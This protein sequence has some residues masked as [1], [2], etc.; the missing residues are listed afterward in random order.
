MYWK[1]VDSKTP[2]DPFDFYYMD[3]NVLFIYLF[4]F[5]TEVIVKLSLNL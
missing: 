4:I 1:S 3:K 5:Y 2:L